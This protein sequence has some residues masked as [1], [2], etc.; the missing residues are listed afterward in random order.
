[1]KKTILFIIAFSSFYM[2]NAQ[3]LWQQ[4]NPS[5]ISLEEKVIS[6]NNK[7]TKFSLFSL[8][9]KKFNTLLA[10]KKRNI[11]NTI[12]LPN[13]KGI[14]QHFEIR[15]TSNFEEGLA[16]KFPNIKSFS[17]KGIDDATAIATISIGTDGTHITIS[18][19]KHNTLYI[20]PYTKDKSVY[21]MYSKKDMNTKKSFSCKTKN[22]E[23]P[24]LRKRTAKRNANDGKLRTYRLALACTA[25]YAQFHLNNQ[26][27]PT[28]ATETEKKTAVLSAMNTTM[29]RVNGIYERDLSVKMVLV[30]DNDKLIFLDPTKMNNNDAGILI[31]QSQQVC[32]AI[33]GTNNYDIG[34][35]FS[36]GAGGLAGIRVVCVDGEKANGVTGSEQPINDPY[37]VDYVTHEIGH[38]FG[39]N[40]TFNSS[41]S[42]NRNNSTA[43]EPASG[44]TIMAYAGVCEPLI[45]NNSDAYFHTISI[46]EMWN[47]ITTT[48][49]A[50][51]TNNN[52][53]PPTAN[54]GNDVNIPP[55]TPFVLEGTATDTDN[56]NLSYTW[57]QIDNGI[58][59]QPP[60]STNTE[61]PLF[62]SVFP[63]ENN[64]RYFPKLSTVI[65]NSSSQWEVLPSV[66]RELNFAFTVRDNNANGGATARDDIKITVVASEP[67]TVTYPKTNNALNIGSTEPVIWNVGATNGE[68][69]N[70]QFVTIKLSTDGGI[71][72]P[73]T[74]IEKTANDGIENIT[75]PNIQ[76]DNARIMVKAVDNIFYN[77]NP[78]NFK[79]SANNPTFLLSNNTS[80]NK[81]NTF[82][83]ANKTATYRLNVETMNGFAETISFKTENLPDGAVAT[84]TPTTLNGNG[85]VTL[86]ISNLAEIPINKYTFSVFANSNSLIRSLQLPLNIYNDFLIFPNPAKNRAFNLTLDVENKKQ[87][88]I[89]LYN[90]N[91][92]LVATKIYNNTSNVFSENLSFNVASGMYL[93]QVDNGGR[94][95]TKKVIFQ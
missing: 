86:T 45:Q 7:P 82:N 4:V 6:E 36:T 70:C 12:T 80:L 32:D 51:I 43:V 49:C 15:E 65:A 73:I 56:S 8:N 58:A 19:E 22:D 62:K 92:R 25:E 78:V 67:F 59:I 3:T 69:I 47:Y 68:A 5:A 72:F 94:T 54:A 9:T 18:S 71:T 13:E 46:E 38:Q 74:L 2:L 16:Q 77:V 34:H 85:E 89:R 95:L 37:N 27:I 81:E 41:C 87:T 14:L 52:N 57:E 48:T 24:T 60:L 76:T 31:G 61:G 21:M 33:I 40:H 23:N 50:T 88:T 1:M 84:F 75:I 39:A 11:E 42:G 44:S 64:K 55:S 10:T 79:I 26:N 66:A 20:D 29:T 83:S 90:L 17:A 91:G 28:T 63:S 30:N 53:K 35:T 93:L